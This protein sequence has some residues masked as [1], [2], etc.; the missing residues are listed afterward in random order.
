[1]P[2]PVTE[3]VAASARHTTGYLACGP[4]DGPLIVFVHGWPE[5]SLSWRHQLPHFG[6][7]GFRAVAPDM[8]GYGQTDRPAAVDQYTILHLVGDMV[9]VL[10]ALG[11]ATAVIV[12]HDWGAPVAWQSARLRPDRFRAVAGMSVPFIP[13]AAQPP[14]CSMPRSDDAEFYMLYFQRPGVADAE[15][16]RDVRKTISSLLYGGSGDAGTAAR[17]AFSMVSPQRGVL[18]HRALPAQRPGWLSEADIDFYTGEFERTGFTG[19]LNWYRNLDRSWELM[20]PFTNLPVPVPALFIAGEL[21]AV[22]TFRGMDKLVPNLKMFVPQ[23]R[24]SLLLPGCGHWVQQERPRE[25][26][27]R[28]LRWLKGL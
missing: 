25:V 2:L 18:E 6:A 4:S 16:A 3:H 27:E 20:A 17:A 13:R 24:E 15:L 22:L 19:G 9:G 11:E 12:G 7:L 1:M 21:D 28:L 5:L 8:R 14:T 26:N 23:L 10:D